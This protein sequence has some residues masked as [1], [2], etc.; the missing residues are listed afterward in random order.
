MRKQVSWLI[1]EGSLYMVYRTNV[2][3]FSLNL[4]DAKRQF[5]NLKRRFRKKKAKYKKATR[6]GSWSREVKQ[7][8]TELKKYDYLS[9]VATYLRLKENTVS[10]LPNTQM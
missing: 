5:D 1:V 10:N 7:A 3:I 4:S 2:H 9:W 8:E 6:S